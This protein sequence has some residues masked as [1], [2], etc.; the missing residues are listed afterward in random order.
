MSLQFILGRAGSGKSSYLL[1]HIKKQLQ[2]NPQGDPI[3]YLVPDQMTFQAEYDLITDPN[4]QGMI[5][6]QVFSF[7]RLALRVL[8]EVGGISRYHLNHVGLSMI[9]RKIIEQRKQDLKVFQRS[10][11]Q[12]GFY[13][14]L[15]Q[16]VTEFKRY[17]ITTEKLEQTIDLDQVEQPNQEEHSGQT[18]S[19]LLVDKLHDLQLIYADFQQHLLGQYVDSEDYLHL[20]AEKIPQST[21]LKNAQILVDG[22]YHFTPQELEV[23]QALIKGCPQ[24]K[25]ALTVDRAYQDV[26]PDE[27]DLFYSTA[28]TYQQVRQLALE[29]N[30]SVLA[31][32]R[33]MEPPIRH[34]GEP[35]L[36]H[37]EINYD[38]RPVVPYDE[39][40]AFIL[41]GAVNRR[42][43]VQGVARQIVSL[44]RDKGYRW[45]D[46]AV[47]VR[48]L[49]PYHDLL[50]TVFEDHGI[51][52][53]IDQKRSMLHHPLIEFIR[54]SLDIIS[55]NWRYEAVFRCVK[56]D[57][58]L[59]WNHPSELKVL[60]EE[61]DQLENYVLAY[62]MSGKRW[63]EEQPW[64]YYRHLS[65][66]EDTLIQSEDD[67]KK[68]ERFHELRQLIVQ[69]LHHLQQRLLKAKSVREMC[70]ELYLYLESVHV[71]E[72]LDHWCKLAE[73]KGH[74]RVAREH[75][76]VWTAVIELLDQLVEMMGEES[77]SL[78]MF[79]K[80]IETGCD[81]MRF[82]LVPP[83]MDQVLVG[84]IE[85]S[86]FSSVKCSFILGANDGILPAR[87]VEEGLISEEEREALASIGIELAP[88]SKQQ[89]ALEHFYI[90]LTLS[91]ASG[92][93]WLSYALAN[94][95]GK[96]L[97]PSILINRIKQMYPKLKEQLIVNDPFEMEEE[98]QLKFIS[99][100]HN[101]LSYL[102]SELRHWRK[103]YPIAPF[104]WDVYNWFVRDEAWKH[105]SQA[106]LSSLFYKNVANPLPNQ[107]S[108]VLYG[109]HIQ[110]SVSR[111]ERF[112][113]CPFSHFISHGLRLKER[114]TYRLEAPDI[115]QLFHAALKLID[116][117]LR[118]S[119]K[120]WAE[121][122]KEDCQQLAAEVV[123]KIAPRLQFNILFSSN[124]H[125]YIKRKLQQVV[126]RATTVINEHAKSSEFTPIGLEVDFGPQGTLPSMAFTLKNGV[127]MEVIGRIDRV[128]QAIGSQGILLRV[129]DYKSS[130]TALNLS[131]VYHGLSLQ[132]LTYLDVIIT[133]AQEWLGGE[134]SPAGVLYFHIHNPMLNKKTALPQDQIDREL[135]R[136]FKMKGL[137]LADQEA[138]QLMDTSLESQHSEVIPVA[139]KKDGQFYSNSSVASREEFEHLRGYVRQQI[140]DIGTQITDG[141]IDITP[142]QM[143]KKIAC[144][145]CSYKAVCQF[146]QD[147]EDN[148]FILLPAASKQT[149][150]EKLRE[151]G[152][153]LDD[154]QNT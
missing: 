101:T 96:S 32:A 108:Q 106:I 67:V 26:L 35:S 131:E 93:L 29:E 40:P 103:G 100:P 114:T 66:E 2:E 143:K 12:Q 65:L 82:A 22:F 14:H 51:P 1:N 76:Q 138:V 102:A 21:Y 31:D 116:D 58:L 124:R 81:S 94:E 63:T 60:R 110:S 112:K 140:M 136:Q 68:Q 50:E 79:I 117:Q 149:V 104:W 142:F 33:M 147:L 153:R 135:Y 95:E 113:A 89:L 19:N 70:E 69:P 20:L 3:I 46:M 91:S 39:D 74:L 64:S 125:H 45:K 23:L 92:H 83:A 42:A 80:M 134:A 150:L 17:C 49:N 38:Q 57:L 121:L 54:S 87:P 9:L 97:T 109:Q 99:G 43:E 47:F 119:G 15:T 132:M 48:D 52:L 152:G 73:G 151:Q 34:R 144:T 24:V 127:T 115:G 27:L 37:F 137:V 85:R 145:F 71:P 18:L 36:A 55:Q 148:E 72:K 7:S 78:D 11:D 141:H 56:T 84:N 8:Q 53:F 59:P 13:E 123:Q 4:L 75:D 41:A 6:T 10:S 30:V 90:Y 98:E 111:M 25:I 86:R 88:D 154:E 105:K 28:R 129:I 120:K 44:V 62:G 16:M 139:I 146:D 77:F 133:H 122:S 61:L 128:D 5:R 107:T 130:Q 126:E 118:L